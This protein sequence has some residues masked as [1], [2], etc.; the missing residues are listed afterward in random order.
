MSPKTVS[1]ATFARETGKL[2]KVA[3]TRPVLVKAT[4]KPTLVIRRLADDDL[5]DELIVRHPK[6][7]ASVRKARANLRAGR[8]VTLEEAKRQLR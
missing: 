6:F 3:Q 2:L 7:R 1:Q 4:G 5:A 8:Y